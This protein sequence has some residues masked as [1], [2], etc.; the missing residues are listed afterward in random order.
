[1]KDNCIAAQFVFDH[2]HGLFQ[3]GRLKDLDTQLYL[4][5][6]KDLKFH[7]LLNLRMGKDD[8]P[9]DGALY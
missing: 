1:M 7:A 9:L 8:D 3:I 4:H 2:C 6:P 5:H